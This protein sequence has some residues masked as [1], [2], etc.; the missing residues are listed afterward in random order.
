MRLISLT[1]SL[2]SL[3]ICEAHQLCRN[4]FDELCN[5]FDEFGNEFDEFGDA[6]DWF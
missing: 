2:M 5:E 6:F 3:C 1:M 4:E